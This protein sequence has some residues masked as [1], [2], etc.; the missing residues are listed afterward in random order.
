MSPQDPKERPGP[1]HPHPG[2]KPGDLDPHGHR[3]T[4]VDQGGSA[5]QEQPGQHH[6]HTGHKPGDL[7]PH[8]HRDT[9]SQSGQ[10]Q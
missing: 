5:Q 1:H 4:S 6:P 10:G 9:G 2:H 7:D 8:G 3:D